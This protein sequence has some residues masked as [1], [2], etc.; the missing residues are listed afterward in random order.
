LA[1]KASDLMSLLAHRGSLRR[2]SRAGALHQ[3]GRRLRAIVLGRS[4]PQQ[5]RRSSSGL[6]VVAAVIACLGIGYLLGNAFPWPHGQGGGELSARTG[7]RGGIAPGPLGEEEDLRPRS[8]QFFLATAYG[9]LADATA[10]A[11]A[12]RKTGQA[13]LSKAGVQQVSFEDKATKALRT[14]YTLVVYFDGT[15][16]KDQARSAL[17]TV[18]APDD[19]FETERKAGFEAER[20]AEGDWPVEQVVR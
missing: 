6:P 14:G 13:G 8:N 17:R 9:Q 16:E 1:R 20:K 12:L 18:A 19:H 10:A 4:D 2:S 11:R 15:R 5:L 7:Q 3:W